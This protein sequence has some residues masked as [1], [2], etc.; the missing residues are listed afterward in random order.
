[1]RTAARALV[2]GVAP[3]AVCRD[4]GIASTA[5]DVTPSAISPYVPLDGVHEEF[6]LLGVM[7]SQSVEEFTDLADDLVLLLRGLDNTAAE[8]FDGCDHLPVLTLERRNTRGVV[9]R[10]G[11]D[12]LEKPLLG[13][14]P[15]EVLEQGLAESPEHRPERLESFG[16][17]EGTAELAQLRVVTT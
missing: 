6:A 3:E 4:R 12:S 10:G 16:S 8:I 2:L 13:F 7:S 14:L 11:R 5:S 15:S 1:M 9:R 17:P